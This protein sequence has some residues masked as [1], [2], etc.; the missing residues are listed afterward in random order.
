MLDAAMARATNSQAE[1]L[2][3]VAGLSPDIKHTQNHTYRI[4]LHNYYSYIS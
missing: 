2:S 3:G 4:H 1:K